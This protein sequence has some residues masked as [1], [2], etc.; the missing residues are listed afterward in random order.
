MKANQLNVNKRSCGDVQQVQAPAAAAAAAAAGSSSD[1]AAVPPV[2]LA[3]LPVLRVPLGCAEEVPSALA[4]IRFAYTGEVAAGS[5]VR[6][7]LELYRQGQYLQVKGCGESCLAAITSKLTA[8]GSS[9]GGGRGS[10]GGGNS[11]VGGRSSAQSCPAALQLYECLRLWPDLALEAAFTP[12]LLEARKRLVAHFGDALAAL[13]TPELRQQLLALPAEGLEALLESDD[14]G[15]DVEDS[16]LLLLATWVEENS[17][18]ADAEVVERLCRLVRLAQLSPD[19]AGA[20]LPLLACARSARPK[21]QS[22]AGGPGWFPITGTE[23]VFFISYCATTVSSAAKRLR[24]HETAQAVHDLQAPWFSTKPRRQCLMGSA[25][26]FA[27]A[28]GPSARRHTFE[29][30]IHQEKL[31]EQL[32]GLQPGGEVHICGSRDSGLDTVCTAGFEWRPSIVYKHGAAVAGVFLCCDLPA[33]YH[34]GESSLGGPVTQVMSPGSLP[35][36]PSST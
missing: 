11:G 1:G 25:V 8:L 28:L 12:V 34:L 4:A 21:R 5:S 7:A 29:W 36:A 22:G 26:S 15:T 31:E 13:N 10:S 9:S 14:F 27:A 20:V 6:E 30:S 23:A 19:F 2:G 32:R 35:C 24:L 16:V 18:R 3:C 17:S 33:A